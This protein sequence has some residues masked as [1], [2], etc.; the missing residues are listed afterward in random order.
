MESSRL[1]PNATKR[2]DPEVAVTFRNECPRLSRTVTVAAPHD[3]R[4]EYLIMSEAQVTVDIGCNAKGV[5]G[6]VAI[7]SED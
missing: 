4:I 7:V 2:G 5:F 6:R 1:G 3:S